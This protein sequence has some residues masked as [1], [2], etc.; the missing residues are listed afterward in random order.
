M[1]Y[2]SFIN[3]YLNNLS[4]T[5]IILC[6]AL[7]KKKID[8]FKIENI[9]SVKYVFRKKGYVKV[10]KVTVLEEGFRY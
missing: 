8:N 2:L 9:N 4:S 5:L 6:S 10:I 3:K 7:N 1:I